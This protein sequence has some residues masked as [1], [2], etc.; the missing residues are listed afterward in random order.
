MGWLVSLATEEVAVVLGYSFEHQSF[1]V[2]NRDDYEWSA[3]DLSGF[4][5]LLD[6]DQV[7][8]TPW[9]KQVFGIVDEIWLHDPYIR[10]FVESA[11]HD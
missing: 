4:S 2:R 8:G 7:I 6:R 10:Q 3:V 5:N 9:A 1:M 11:G